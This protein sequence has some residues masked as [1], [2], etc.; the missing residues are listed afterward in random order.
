MQF[1]N[2]LNT[3]QLVQYGTKITLIS[4]IE[5]PAIG[6]LRR[7]RDPVVQPL[8][9]YDHSWVSRLVIP[10]PWASLGYYETGQ[11]ITLTFERFKLEQVFILKFYAA[12]SQR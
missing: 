12:K 3:S 1:D 2:D 8:I 10:F 9:R 11:R 7:R 6:Q 5:N 4:I